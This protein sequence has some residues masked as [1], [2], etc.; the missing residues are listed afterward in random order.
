[1]NR[2]NAF[3]TLIII[4][5]KNKIKICTAIV[6]VGVVIKCLRLVSV[7]IRASCVCLSLCPS[8]MSVCYIIQALMMMMTAASVVVGCMYVCYI[9]MTGSLIVCQIAFWFHMC[10]TTSLRV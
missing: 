4:H 9:M 2:K 1:M 3:T 8:P 10:N 6:A 7:N 5:K